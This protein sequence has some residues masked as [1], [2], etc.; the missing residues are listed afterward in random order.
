[1]GKKSVH[2]DWV[3]ILRGG[4]HFVGGYVACVAC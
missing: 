4:K 2:L 3:D 1:M